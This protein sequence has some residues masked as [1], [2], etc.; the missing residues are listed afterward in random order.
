MAPGSRRLATL[1]LALLTF[2]VASE[3]NGNPFVSAFVGGLAFGAVAGRDTIASVELT[4]LG[5]GLLSLVVWFIFGA[6]FV[7]PAFEH[8][9]GRVVLYAVASLTVVRMVPVAIALTGSGL[10]RATTGFVGWFG[11]R[12]LAS[13]VFALL[14]VEELGNSDPRVVAALNAIVITVV[15]SVV[16]HGLTAGP[17]TTRYVKTLETSRRGG[18]A[19]RVGP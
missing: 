2:L 8:A 5:G 3:A 18:S 7:L 16:A 17:L 9:G 1:A 14:A 12:G 15:L 4:A 6:G 10:G 11:P 19:A 13:V